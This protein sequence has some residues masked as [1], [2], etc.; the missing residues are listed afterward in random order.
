MCAL[1]E[2]SSGGAHMY[3][4]CITYVFVV[5][6]A[7]HTSCTMRARPHLLHAARHE[8][9]VPPRCRRRPYRALLQVRSISQT[10]PPFF[11]SALL[12]LARIGCLLLASTHWLLFRRVSSG[13]RLYTCK[14]IQ[15]IF[16]G[17]ASS[18]VS[19]TLRCAFYCVRDKLWLKHT[20]FNL[21]LFIVS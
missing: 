20:Q 2:T 6:A 7:L 8:C 21:V 4:I 18:I 17:F 13:E 11:I 3:D 10:F 15:L 16:L 12:T 14:T 19:L 5:R 1:N 9:R